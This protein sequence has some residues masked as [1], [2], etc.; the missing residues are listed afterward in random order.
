MRVIP[1]IDLMNGQVVRGVGGRRSEYRPIHSQIA[2]DASPSTVAATFAADF[3]FDTVYVADL[4][5][6][7]HGSP[8][9]DA[10]ERIAACDLKLWLDAGLGTLDEAK[11]VSRQSEL[12]GLNIRSVIG[13]ESLR[14]INELA[15]IGQHIADPIFSLDLKDGIP[16]VRCAEWRDANPLEI[17]QAVLDCGIAD[18]IVLDLA[19]VGTSGGTRTLDLC[20]AIRRQG[21]FREVIAGG[22]VRGQ[23]DLKALANA[24]C[25]AALVASALHDG[26]LTQGELRQLAAGV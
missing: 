6:I 4:D 17:A 3:G 24:G 22:G 23:S 8:D 25:S 9:F 1:V 10:W 18:L 7:M 2:A 20:Q 26:R 16:Q 12:L 13:L 21:N 5:A 11:D 15:A 19:D 14:S